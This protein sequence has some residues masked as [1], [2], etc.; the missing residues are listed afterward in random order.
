LVGETVATLTSRH[1][2]S[3]L[4]NASPTDNGA[5]QDELDSLLK[6]GVLPK[7]FMKKCGLSGAV[8]GAEKALREI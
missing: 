5:A 8:A 3:R 7:P 6:S 2:V 1:I 4:K